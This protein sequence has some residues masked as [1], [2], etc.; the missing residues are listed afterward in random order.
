MDRVL[1]KADGDEFGCQYHGLS[2]IIEA[3][4]CAEV[5]FSFA[6]G[7]DLFCAGFTFD[8]GVV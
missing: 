1:L 4:K 3:F 5:H 8:S 2:V 6:S 7:E